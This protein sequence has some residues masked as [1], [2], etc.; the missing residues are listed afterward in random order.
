MIHIVI[1]RRL[2][3][4]G[5]RRVS[6]PV[7][8]VVLVLVIVLILFT[9]FPTQVNDQIKQSDTD[10]AESWPLS[11]PNDVIGNNQVVRPDL[12]HKIPVF[13]DEVLGNDWTVIT[14]IL[15]IDFSSN[16]RQF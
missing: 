9:L 16:L 8:A 13:R 2:R 4:L 7:L 10:S 11:G 14:L 1:P 3:V 6:T 12:N 15:I 5:F